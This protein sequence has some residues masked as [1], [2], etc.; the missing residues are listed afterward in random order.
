MIG[1]MLGHY[2]L[3]ER[4]DSGGMGVVYRARD[5]RLER[6]VGIKVLTEETLS[7]P[8]ARA[9]LLREARTASS[10]NHAHICVIHEVGEDAGVAFIAMEL[11]PGQ[12][13]QRLVAP[14]GLPAATVLRYGIQIADALSHAHARGVIHRDLKSANVMVTPEGQVKVLDFGLA[15]KVRTADSSTVAV[16]SALLTETGAIVGTPHYMPPELLRGGE[17]DA[18]S[19]IWALGV[20]LH[21]MAAGEMPFAGKTS[22]EVAAAI[23][24]APPGPL[25]AS[26]PAGLRAVIARCLEKDPVHRYGAA[27][28][29]HAALEAL[30]SGSVPAEALRPAAQVSQ[31]APPRS[32]ATRRAVMAIAAA[33]LVL[34]ALWMLNPGRWRDRFAG[35][36]AA[37][38]RSLAV[39]PMINL[40]GDPG[41]EYFADGMTEE[42]ITILTKISA[43]SVVSMSS[44]KGLKAPDRPLREIARE[45][46]V[47][48]ILRGS[49]RRSAERVRISAQLVDAATNRNLW[50]E[51]YERSLADVLA[52]QSEVAL[53]IAREIQLKLTPR[54]QASISATRSVDPEAH[55]AFLMGRFEM[56]RLTQESLERAV[57][58]FERAIQID[59][60][61]GAAYAGLAEAYYFLNTWVLPPHQAMPLVRASARKALQ[62]DPDLAIAYS[63]LAVVNAHYEF[64][65]AGA[66]TNLR[67]AISL[68]PGDAG[69]HHWYGSYLLL[70]GR[71]DE[72]ELEFLKA[73]ELDPLTPGTQWHATFPSFYRGD[74]SRTL[75][76]LNGLRARNA[77]EWTTFSLLGETFEQMGQYDSASVALRKSLAL[78]GNPWV[79]AAIGRVH[80]AAGRRDSARAVLDQ[81]NDLG[82]RRYVT[83]YAVASV[84]AALGERDRAFELLED[85]FSERTEDLILIKIDPRL[86]P[87]RGDPRFTDLL[88]RM[89]LE[90]TSSRGR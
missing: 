7:D 81:L 33:T 73:L 75:H 14:P 21:E 85:A 1:R 63:M 58:S 18:R 29:V 79:L 57:A 59:S 83:P 49:V 39:L 68:A 86:K 37:S 24:N 12:S 10:L 66:D 2:R 17:A 26:V 72:A 46:R 42:L 67:R 15:R 35:G 53:A 36:D 90:E 76:Q 6:D 44:V 78:G 48:L 43:L 89:G 11:V 88:R 54:E 22:F 55:Q 74:Y 47:A 3:L 31:A 23:M 71:F 34:A 41:Q 50:A 16:P 30:R 28:E 87:L 69:T 27:G 61:Y 80:V 77:G 8:I 4:I 20:V 52:L 56:R 40:S 25:P 9:R 38:T 60:T 70:Q 65:W 32:V 84:Y 45:L 19:D 62:R 82:R 51:S 5:V 64:S 13:L